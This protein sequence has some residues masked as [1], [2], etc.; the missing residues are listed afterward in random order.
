[1]QKASVET[2]KSYMIVNDAAFVD[3]SSRNDL[4]KFDNFN[5]L[6]RGN[7][8]ARRSTVLPHIA[9]SWCI[10]NIRLVAGRR[11]NVSQIM[12]YS[13]PK[14]ALGSMTSSRAN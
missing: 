12:Y 14:A 10:L 13:A 4:K 5:G 8:W 1:M 2:D 9:E 6:M 7:M 3:I 11:A